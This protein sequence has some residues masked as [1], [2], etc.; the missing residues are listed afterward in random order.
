[1]VAV[2]PEEALVE[3]IITPCIQARILCTQRQRQ[4][5]LLLPRE[6]VM[7]TATVVTFPCNSIQECSTTTLVDMQ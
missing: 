3:A 6:V 7:L 5:Q 1:M 2:H 4:P